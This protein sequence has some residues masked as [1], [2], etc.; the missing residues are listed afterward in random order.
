MGQKFTQL[1]NTAFPDVETFFL[2]YAPT[3]QYV[4]LISKYIP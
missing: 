3:Y 2:K 1:K 4:K